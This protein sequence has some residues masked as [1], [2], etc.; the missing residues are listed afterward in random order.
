[1]CRVWEYT[2]N[3]GRLWHPTVTSLRLSGTLHT[4]PQDYLTPYTYLWHPT[5][6]SREQD[7]L[8]TPLPPYANLQRQSL[9]GFL[10]S[11]V[12]REKVI[13]IPY[14]RLLQTFWHPTHTSSRLSETLYTP[15]SPYTHLL[16]IFWHPAHISWRLCDTLHTPLTPYTRLWHPHTEHLEPS[17]H[18]CDTTCRVWKYTFNTCKLWQPTHALLRLSDTLHT[19]P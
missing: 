11:Y 19:P 12:S 17:K 16:E 7:T 2:Y 1:M 10:T 9:W 4:S 13:F 14:T 8:H 6:T 15:M 18:K 3:R 5:P